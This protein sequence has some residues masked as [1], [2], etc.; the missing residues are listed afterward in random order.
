MFFPSAAASAPYVDMRVAGGKLSH[1]LPKL[2]RGSAFQ[3]AQF[4]KLHLIHRD[5]IRTK[6]ADAT[7][8]VS[9]LKC[10]IKFQRVRTVAFMVL[11]MVSGE[12][13]PSCKAV[14]VFASDIYDLLKSG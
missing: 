9:R 11:A 3:M 10:R 12:R 13:E 6:A 4:A 2:F 7:D 8:P 14:V 5:G 1:L